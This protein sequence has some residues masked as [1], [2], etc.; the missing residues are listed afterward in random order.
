MVKKDNK[1]PSA[2]IVEATEDFVKKNPLT[3]IIAASIIGYAIG[4]IIHK[5]SK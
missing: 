3:S 4:R 5:R 2:Q 1:E